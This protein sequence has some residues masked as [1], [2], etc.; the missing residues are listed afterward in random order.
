MRART[1]HLKHLMF[2]MHTVYSS[3]RQGSTREKDVYHHVWVIFHDHVI[4]IP[5]LIWGHAYM[6]LYQWVIEGQRK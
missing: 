2:H 3:H 4:A 6:G 5:K 1:K